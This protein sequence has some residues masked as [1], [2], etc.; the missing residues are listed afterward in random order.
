MKTV[1][2]TMMASLFLALGLAGCADPVVGKWEGKDDSAVD[3][4]VQS[5]NGGDYDGDGHIY[6]CSDTDCYLCPF[7]FDANNRGGGRFEID[8]HFT[9]D[10]SSAGSFDGID[11]EVRGDELT[12][13]IPGGPTIEYDRAR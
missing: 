10:C 2:T 12:C 9:G 4:D 13:D 3:L 1:A 7:D 6:L 5:A 8:G 11:C